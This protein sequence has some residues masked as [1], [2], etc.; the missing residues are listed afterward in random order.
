MS[1]I[2]A[3]RA[4]TTGDELVGRT[5][6]EIRHTEHHEAGQASRNP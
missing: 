6:T 5:L 3:P 1:G 4:R 2:A